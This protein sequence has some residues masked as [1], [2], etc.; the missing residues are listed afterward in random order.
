VEEE[1]ISKTTL[2]HC[3]L[4]IAGLCSSFQAVAPPV[5]RIINLI[6]KPR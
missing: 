2:I 1:P 3:R 4:M 5:H 6:K